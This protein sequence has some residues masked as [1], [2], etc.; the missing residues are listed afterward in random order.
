[1]RTA[2]ITQKT[3]NAMESHRLNDSHKIKARR[4][5]WRWVNRRRST[6]TFKSDGKWYEGMDSID[7]AQLA[8]SYK[9][10]RLEKRYWNL[11][12]SYIFWRWDDARPIYYCVTT[13][14][15]DSFL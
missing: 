14:C 5:T 9:S 10:G 1:M 13:K 12:K 15:F 8:L 7:V 6:P 2:N 4:V 3:L 11:A